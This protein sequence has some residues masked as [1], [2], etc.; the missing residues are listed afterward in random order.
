MTEEEA[1]G[2]QGSRWQRAE[3]VVGL[4]M[5]QFQGH[6][7]PLSLAE[8]AEHTGLSKSALLRALS[9]A[10]QRGDLVRVDDFAWRRG[11]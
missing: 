2:C 11:A 6:D 3:Q 9:L 7:L 5:I 8:L 4:L 10:E 1:K